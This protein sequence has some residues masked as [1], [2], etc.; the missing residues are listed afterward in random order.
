VTGFRTAKRSTAL[1]DASGH[2][3]ALAI[4]RGAF[5]SCAVR[6]MPNLDL[7]RPVHQARFRFS[8]TCS[9]EEG[10]SP[11]LVAEAPVYSS[12]SRSRLYPTV[13]C[14]MFRE[15]VSDPRLAR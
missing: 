10:K 14:E 13:F 7:S 3:C 8:P 11:K 6:Q 5:C 2:G 12:M 15:L 4:R 9:L 1:P